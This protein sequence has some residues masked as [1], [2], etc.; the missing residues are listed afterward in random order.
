M[1][2]QGTRDMDMYAR[3]RNYLPFLEKL[4]LKFLQKNIFVKSDAWNKLGQK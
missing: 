1:I 3:E 2:I 4:L